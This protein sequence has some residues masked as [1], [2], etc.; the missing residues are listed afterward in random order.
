[1]L[2]GSEPR[3]RRHCLE[4]QTSDSGFIFILSG[5]SSPLISNSILGTYRSG[6]F[7]F[8]CPIFL[9]FHTVHGVLKARILKLFVIPLSSGP[10][11][12]RTLHHDPSLHGMAHSFIEL[13]KAV[14]HLF[15]GASKITAD[16][17]CSHEFKSCSLEEKL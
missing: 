13:D 6:D 7:I 11:F 4:D 15:L 1:M 10:R 16:G 17:D 8:Q 9:P 2:R 3:T 14:V 12:V 5:V